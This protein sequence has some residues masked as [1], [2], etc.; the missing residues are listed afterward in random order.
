ML[1]DTIV[2]EGK[3]NLKCW[4]STHDGR[5]A[6][7]R[8]SPR[9]HWPLQWWWW[10][11]IRSIWLMKTCSERWT[12]EINIM[13]DVIKT[14]WPQEFVAKR[15]WT[16]FWLLLKYFLC[17]PAKVVLHF[18]VSTMIRLDLSQGCQF[19]IFKK[20]RFLLLFKWF[21]GYKKLSYQLPRLFL[22]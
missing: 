6:Y 5:E 1:P 19:F 22:F 21:L 3:H 9:Q 20:F 14:L 10:L 7:G 4:T 15:Q 16:C 2:A 18:K 17:S 12:K 8:S 11:I 13:Q